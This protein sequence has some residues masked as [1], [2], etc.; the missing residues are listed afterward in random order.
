M[1][2]H[3]LFYGCNK[4]ISDQLNV[5]HAKMIS[6]NYA[7][8]SIVAENVIDACKQFVFSTNVIKTNPRTDAIMSRCIA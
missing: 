1:R 6:P 4:T 8:K 5:C 2:L 3:G 7:N